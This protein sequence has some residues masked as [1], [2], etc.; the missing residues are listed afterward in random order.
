MFLEFP[1]KTDGSTDGAT[2]PKH[3]A[4]WKHKMQSMVKVLYLFSELYSQIKCLLIKLDNQ[5]KII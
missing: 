3:N 5:I 1:Q 4:K 2:V